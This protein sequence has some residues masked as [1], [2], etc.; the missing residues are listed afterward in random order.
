MSIPVAR[1]R[2]GIALYNAALDEWLVIPVPVEKPC[3]VPVVGDLYYRR[4]RNAGD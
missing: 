1:W 4:K 2:G 3:E